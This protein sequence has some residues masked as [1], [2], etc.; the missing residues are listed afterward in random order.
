[1]HTLPLLQL[2]LL[3]SSVSAFFPFAPDW[4]QKQDGTLSAREV[5]RDVDGEGASGFSLGLQRKP[6]VTST[7]P[8]E[9]AA[10]EAKRLATKYQRSHPAQGET[11]PDVVRRSNQY[12]VT[13]ADD[14]SKDMTAG[15]NQDGA[16]YSYF[17]KVKLGSKSKSMY[18]LVDT[19]AGSSWVMGSSCTSKAC[20][21][22]STFGP[23]DSSTFKTANKDFSISYGSGT[24]SGTL[25]TDTISLAGVS[26]TYNFGLAS[27]TSDD[28]TRFAF[29]GILGLSMSQGANDN[30]VKSMG[31][32]KKLDKSMFAVSLNRASDGTNTGEIR[33]GSTNSDKYKGD[34][35][36][37][38]VSSS[39]GDWAIQL[40]D[41]TYD[42]S[43]A[44]VGGVKS[45]ID[46]GTSFIFG[47]ADLVKKV[48]GVIPGS[49]SGDGL[50]YTV[51]C[52]S[53][54][55]TLTFSGVDFAIS[56]KDWVSPKDSSGKCT[57]NIYGHEAVPGAWLLGDTFL[58]NVY[59]VFDKDQKRIGFAKPAGG[60][61][62]GS[63]SSSGKGT[64]SAT[65]TSTLLAT[66]VSSQQSGKPTLGL[67]GHE[68][69]SGGATA[70]GDATKPTET[71][72]SAAPAGGARIATKLC[73]GIAMA[74][75]L[76][77]LV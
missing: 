48:H 60:S 54:P 20:T 13:G 43:K 69:Q 26:F 62:T 22:H 2:A 47:P 15:V 41:V 35:T 77:A 45:Y 19:G 36:Y 27:N 46:T 10:R 7:K 76:A 33:F 50:T 55:L 34:I 3:T 5:N 39:G 70:T 11:S 12:P 8:A 9:R 38:P 6:D 1:M 52:D 4:L 56:P 51:P 16:D 24:V 71:S 66:G 18:M 23:D 17:V 73:T 75:L 14:P 65:G 64:A 67:G 30:F 49:E 72:H 68:T 32:A 37:T 59:A 58:K 40:D 28:F 31:D 21:M 44:Q 53:K 63:S 74:A 29:D 61:Q 57:S 42:G 25:A